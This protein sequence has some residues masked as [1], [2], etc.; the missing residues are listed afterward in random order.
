MSVSTGPP[1]VRDITY[2][3]PLV[4]RCV[5]R[6]CV[7]AV[8]DDGGGAKCLLSVSSRPTTSLEETKRGNHLP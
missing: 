7:V 6:V 4:V 5:E 8:V 2:N 3:V 1:D